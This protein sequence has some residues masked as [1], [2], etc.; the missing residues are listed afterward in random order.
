MA[1]TLCHEGMGKIPQSFP[2]KFA[3]GKKNFSPVHISE[4]VRRTEQK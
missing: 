3:V 1:S 2:L 4:T